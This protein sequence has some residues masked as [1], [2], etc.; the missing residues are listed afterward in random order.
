LINT[1]RSLSSFR[2]S[3]LRR[4]HS[5]TPVFHSGAVGPHLQSGSGARKVT[6]I[7]AVLFAG[8]LS[9]LLYGTYSAAKVHADA[10]DEP[11]RARSRRTR[12]ILHSQKKDTFRGVDVERILTQCE[13]TVLESGTGV[14]R[15]DINQVARYD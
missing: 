9:A 13:E 11:T 12:E 4:L 15:Y 6:A 1:S 7:T 8:G 3:G 14:W 10:S 2:A 5:T